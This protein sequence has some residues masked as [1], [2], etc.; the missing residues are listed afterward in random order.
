MKLSS[1]ITNMLKKWLVLVAQFLLV[2][3][4]LMDKC[5]MCR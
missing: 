1:R 2:L 5:G 3:S 4:E